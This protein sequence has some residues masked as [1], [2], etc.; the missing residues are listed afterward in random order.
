[1]IRVK[2]SQP[3]IPSYIGEFVDED[4]LEKFRH[5][6]TVLGSRVSINDIELVCG[7]TVE[8]LLNVEQ[9]IQIIFAVEDKI[10]RV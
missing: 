2:I 1:M 10:K 4:H 8:K 3:G 5:F 7:I 6:H 9:N